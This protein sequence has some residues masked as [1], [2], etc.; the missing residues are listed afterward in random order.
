M[1]KEN[2]DKDEKLSANERASLK[3]AINNVKPGT[4]GYKGL[5][6]LNSPTGQT[7]KYTAPLLLAAFAAA[8]GAKNQVAANKTIDEYIARGRSPEAMQQRLQIAEENKGLMSQSPS[9]DA[10]DKLIDN[11]RKEVTIPRDN[12]KDLK[13]DYDNYKN[14]SEKE[15][16]NIKEKKL[17]EFDSNQKPLNNLEATRPD[18]GTLGHSKDTA[19]ITYD[20]IKYNYPKI[21]EALLGK[22]QDAIEL[23][24]YGKGMVPYST[25][26][27]K[28]GRGYEKDLFFTE[29]YPL[30]QPHDMFGKEALERIGENLAAFFAGAHHAKLKDLDKLAE[31]ANQ[32][33]GSAFRPYLKKGET[34]EQFFKNLIGLVKSA[35]IFNA[36]TGA[37]PYIE[38]P[39][40]Y[41]KAVEI[42]EKYTK[43]KEIPEEAFDM[44]KNAVVNGKVRQPKNDESELYDIY[45]HD[46]G[47]AVRDA[48]I[49]SSTLWHYENQKM[50]PAL[51]M[52][53]LGML[54]LAAQ[55]Q[56]GM[57][58]KVKNIQE[59]HKAKIKALIN[60][61][62]GRDFDEWAK[63]KSGY[64]KYDKEAVDKLFEKY[65]DE[66]VEDTKK[67]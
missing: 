8:L 13:M 53:A 21:P 32:K 33:F 4:V 56:P 2:K 58:L 1:E 67:D 51:A 9:K 14:L 11:T 41:E 26:N 48:D 42:M 47:K 29:H 18:K 52:G 46:A 34:P 25:F 59:E 40:S 31:E 30:I 10:Q 61:T 35:D 12:Y 20:L 62:R 60:A 24:D 17:N 45:R 63:L 44:F 15:V 7:V 27:S 55:N 43:G 65:F 5:E 28:T 37:R 50:H 3:N 57:A 39:D 22:I 19:R 64:Y 16:K 49:N 54:G 6:H 36:K 38:N 23:H 66:I